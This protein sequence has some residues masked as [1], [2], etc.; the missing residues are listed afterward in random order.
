ME[1]LNI[2][3]LFMCRSTHT[4]GDGYSPIVLRVI[5]RGER[6]DIFTGLYC[7]K[8]DW[9]PTTQKV[10]FA[11]KDITG[12]NKNLDLIIRKAHDCFEELKFSGLSFSIDELI[13]KIKDKEQTPTLLLEYITGCNEKIK[14]RVDVDITKSTYIKYKTCLKHMED[15]LEDVY[16]TRKFSL[17]SMNG[18]FL[19]KY[20]YY[21]RAN[22]NISNNTAVK[23]LQSLRTLIYT[24]VKD[25]VIK[26]DPFA[27]FKMRSKPVHRDYLT[28]DEINQLRDLILESKD[29]ERI[30]DIFLF[31]CYTGLAY[32]DIKQ[33]KD[34]HIIQDTDLSWYIR[35]PRQKTGVESIIPLLPAA[36]RILQKYSLTNSIRDVSW[37]VSTNQKMNQRLKTIGTLAGISKKLHMHLARHTF[38][39]T[40]ALTNGI[41]I[42]SVSKMLGHSS[43]NQT[44][45]YA[46]IIASKVKL[47]MAKINSLYS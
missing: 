16:K 28:Q 13:D 6:K 30:R 7:D 4:N 27:E 15:F 17:H 20:F 8:R 36:I 25:G 18:K 32:S 40:V 23:Y 11:G 43:T 5:Y 47:E 9:D 3:F 21:L 33:L 1:L 41:S 26:R 10:F 34:V 14:L 12:I 44:E 39:T 38:A 35:K 22:K 2:R 37:Y 45:H 42:E 24:A 31:A 46:K 29:L 19:E